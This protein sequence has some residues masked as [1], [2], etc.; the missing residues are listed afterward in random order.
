MRIVRRDP[1]FLVSRDWTSNAAIC[2]AAIAFMVG[3]VNRTPCDYCKAASQKSA[4]HAPAFPKCV[5]VH[6]DPGVS[7]SGFDGPHLLTGKCACCFYRSGSCS[8]ASDLDHLTIA[9]QS[10]YAYKEKK[11]QMLAQHERSGKTVSS[12]PQ[13]ESRSS[14]G[15]ANVTPTPTY[16]QVIE[17]RSSDGPRGSAPIRVGRHRAIHSPAYGDEEESVILTDEKKGSLHLSGAPSGLDWKNIPSEPRHSRELNFRH[18][19]AHVVLQHQLEDMLSRIKTEGQRFRPNKYDWHG[20]RVTPEPPSRSTSRA[21]SQVTSREPSP[22]APSYGSPSVAPSRAPSDDHRS[23]RGRMETVPE[24]RVPVFDSTAQQNEVLR[25]AA[26]EAV[27]QFAAQQAHNFQQMQHQGFPPPTLGPR[28]EALSYHPTPSG[29]FRSSGPVA[30]QAPYYE[31]PRGYPNTP[32]PTGQYSQSASW[33]E[34][35]P[36]FSNGHQQ[37]SQFKVRSTPPRPNFQSSHENMGYGRENW[38]ASG[39]GPTGPNV[40]T[41]EPREPEEMRTTQLLRADSHPRDVIRPSIEVPEA[42][43]GS[44]HSSADFSAHSGAGSKALSMP[45][46]GRASSVELGRQERQ[47]RGHSH[48]SQG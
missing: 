4:N 18:P 19:R 29:H 35:H 30:S 42:R 12:Q 33:N 31:S 36:S 44:E 39:M 41:R 17:K 6:A 45:P 22:V 37:A 15:S 11:K 16:T 3:F 13:A 9:N 28:G 23:K 48:Y 1:E 26:Q 2:A 8:L 21:V 27:Q 43:A 32:L 20:W 14:S 5:S 24:E 40:V 47:L 34:T 7:K 10:R 38:A 25:R 46:A